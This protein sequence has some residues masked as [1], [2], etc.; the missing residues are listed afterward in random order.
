MKG[1]DR[2]GL[3]KQEILR[4]KRNFEYLFQEGR[5]YRTS[6]LNFVYTENGLAYNRIAPLVSNR[7]GNSVFRNSIR[8]VIK[9]IYRR[10]KFELQSGYDICILLNDRR[11][12]IRSFFD[13]QNMVMAGLKKITDQA[14]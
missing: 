5:K 3:V 9:E 7:F 4:G 13:K 1:K 6:C 10:N 14:R 2:A 12:Q 11:F 8:R